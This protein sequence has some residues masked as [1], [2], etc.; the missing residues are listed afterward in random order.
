MRLVKRVIDNLSTL[1]IFN[2]NIDIHD[3]FAKDNI[4][5]DFTT[6]ETTTRSIISCPDILLQHDTSDNV[7]YMTDFEFDQCLNAKNTSEV[8]NILKVKFKKCN[9]D[10]DKINLFRHHFCS[11]IFYTDLYIKSGLILKSSGFI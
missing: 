5:T 9:G 4:C 1:S 7:P 10:K 2:K 6:S 3:H 8:I 11:T